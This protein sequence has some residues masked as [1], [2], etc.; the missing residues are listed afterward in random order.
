MPALN[1]RVPMFVTDL[2]V[3]GQIVFEF[4]LQSA[5][6]EPSAFHLLDLVVL[7]THHLVW[8]LRHVCLQTAQLFLASP[9]RVR[10]FCL[11]NACC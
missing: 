4:V 1:E 2:W 11:A 5:L 9:K 7:G 3:A 10:R 8:V 6:V